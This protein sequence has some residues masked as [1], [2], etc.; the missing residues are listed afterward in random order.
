MLTQLYTIHGEQLTGTPWDVY[1]RPQM[2]RDSSFNLI[3]SEIIIN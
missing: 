3:N 2:R 1:P